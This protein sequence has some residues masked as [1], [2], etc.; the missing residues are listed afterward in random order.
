MDA[1]FMAKMRI[2]SGIFFDLD[3]SPSKL[4]P[5]N[6]LIRV[7]CGAKTA[8]PI[9]QRVIHPQSS[10]SNLIPAPYFLLE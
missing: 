9:R 7:N 6:K 8:S 4:S 10:A 5:Y 2:Q 3:V 1:D